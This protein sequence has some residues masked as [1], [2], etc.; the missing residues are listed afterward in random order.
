MRSQDFES[1]RRCARN[2]HMRLNERIRKS[3]LV[4]P[5]AGMPGLAVNAF[6]PGSLVTQAAQA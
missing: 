4:M 1:T 2:G 5:F 3:R 6:F